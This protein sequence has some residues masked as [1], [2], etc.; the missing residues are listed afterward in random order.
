[1]H[2]QTCIPI[3][4]SL[5]DILSFL[6]DQFHAGHSYRSLNVYHSAISSIHPK[7]DGY[8]IGSHPLVC[9]L[10]KGAFNRRP[11]LPKYQSTWSV[12]TVIVYVKSLGKNEAL[13]LKQITHKL[14]VLLA[15]TMASRSSDFSLLTVTGCNFVQEGIRCTLSGLSKQSRPRHSKSAIEVAHYPDILVCPVMCLK[16]YIE[17]TKK[18]RAYTPTGPQPNQ[19]FIGISKPH[20]PVQACTIA[21][22]VKTVLKEAGINTDIFSAHSTRGASTS[23]AVSGG[24][25]LHVVLSQADWSSCSTFH[26]HYFRPQPFSSFSSAVLR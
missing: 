26:K 1:M 13:S 16:R 25:S 10:L 9:C 11:L 15:L 5:N 14:A 23:A 24:A 2:Q 12:E 20:A 7:I 18:F 8:T 19:L 3:S 17:V 4:S 22:W 6:T 21:R